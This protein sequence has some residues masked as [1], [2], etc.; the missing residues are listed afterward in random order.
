MHPQGRRGAHQTPTGR[1]CSG[2]LVA[3]AC[4]FLAITATARADAPLTEAAAV[5]LA[6]S[7]SA[8]ADVTDGRVALATAE[9][10]R[11]RRWPNP[12]VSFQH[13]EV[14]GQAGTSEDYAWLSQT[15]DLAGR[16][17]IRADAAEHRVTAARAEGEGMLANRRAA[18]RERFYEALLAQE[19]AAAFA[20]WL[21]Q[22]ARIGR[23][24]ERRAQAG[25]ASGYDRR[26]FERE[27]TTIRARLAT[28]EA[29][30]GRARARLAG[31]IGER[32]TPGTTWK[33]LAG[34]LRPGTDLPALADLLAR[35]PARPD[36]RGL[37]AMQGAAALDQRAAGRWW[38]PDLTVGAGV[39][40]VEAGGE[41]LTGPFV[42]AS[43][44][45]PLLDQDQGDAW[46]ATA[47]LRVS[48]GEYQLALDAAEAEI[49]GFWS[50]TAALTWAAAEFRRDTVE[51]STALVDIAE[52]AYQAGEMDLL[53]LVDAHRGA[54]DVA[55]QAL[56]LD[57]NARRAWIDLAR[58]AGGDL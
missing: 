44:P 37:L 14:E 25:E 31:L 13:E 32:D 55:L 18:V 52:R 58:A 17:Y 39:K 35:V 7:R 4:V 48:R 26:R 6:L 10:E 43:L 20:A 2:M 49:R 23:I 36:L 45:L 21:E 16:R 30:L 5:A 34:P 27:V 42:S 1:R 9:R 46:E 8:L 41:R 38:L 33:M 56:A 12:V 22:G 3:L 51:P 29:E 54:L 24:I 11:V 40:T 57:L 53:G 28:T 50:E 47:R 19:R 15:F